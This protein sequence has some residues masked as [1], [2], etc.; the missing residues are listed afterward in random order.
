VL[1]AA[2]LWPATIV[3]ASSS[4]APAAVGR[5]STE[6][7]N[8][9]PKA[10]RSMTGA[11]FSLESASSSALLNSSQAADFKT[12]RHKAAISPSGRR[13]RASV[14]RK[15]K[16]RASAAGMEIVLPEPRSSSVT[17]ASA[18]ISTGVK[19]APGLKPTQRS[20]PEPLTVEGEPK[21]TTACE[22]ESAWDASHVP[23]RHRH[24]L[25]L[26]SLTGSF[27]PRP[28]TSSAPA[29]SARRVPAP[30][31]PIERA[32][33]RQ[34]APPLPHSP[35]RIRLSSPPAHLKA[36]TPPGDILQ[37]ADYFSY[38]SPTRNLFG[39]GSAG[40]SSPLTPLSSS[41]A[42]SSPLR[43]PLPPTSPTR[44]SATPQEL[45]PAR[46]K[47]TPLV[48]ASPSRTPTRSATNLSALFDQH[49]RGSGSSGAGSEGDN[50]I[51]SDNQGR[52]PAAASSSSMPF[53][54]GGVDEEGGSLGQ[55]VNL[56]AGRR[57]VDR[58][59]QRSNTAPSLTSVGTR[60]SGSGDRTPLGKRTISAL[61][62]SPDRHKNDGP[63]PSAV[64]DIP[65][66]PSPSASKTNS[67]SSLS[68]VRP[69]GSQQ[70][71]IKRR[72][73]G[74]SS[75][76]MLAAAN[77]VDDDGGGDGGERES[78]V[79][80]AKRWGVDQGRHG[81][82]EHDFVDVSRTFATLR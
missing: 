74:G 62:P 69:H 27:D 41:V 44:R 12:A 33:P 1:I 10:K 3:V 55:L 77:P 31:K 26:C 39:V 70:Q 82:G 23:T 53:G 71:Q 48:P 75:R 6:L 63:A 18:A 29:A 59:L 61:F 51:K 30:A 79:K 4:K 57:R 65:V 50:V 49:I 17:G 73:Y 38:P 11:T 20:A 81:A 52:S 19:A 42:Q 45:L 32:A 46:S 8:S 40:P 47:P 25:T 22:S 76:S 43:R 7:S 78:Y 16:S 60:P 2:E 21:R 67:P 64:W 14:D 58:L 35:K 72:T 68:P 9:A 5:L 54:S 37:Q 36:Q 56:P 28:S 80:M 34:A 24:M 66:L 13:V 15:G